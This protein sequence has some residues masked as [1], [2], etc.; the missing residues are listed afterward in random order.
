M[1]PDFEIGGGTEIGVGG[2]PRPRPSIFVRL[3]EMAGLALVAYGLGTNRFVLAALGGG[4]I[5]VSYAVYRRK[6]GTSQPTRSDGDRG[7]MD[8][9]GGGD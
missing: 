4:T 8:T 3:L 5:I 2:T 1:G 9:D 7:G 6:H